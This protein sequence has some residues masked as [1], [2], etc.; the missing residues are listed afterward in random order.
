M[1]GK[2][3]GAGAGAGSGASALGGRFRGLFGNES[4]QDS[5][6][7]TSNF[8]STYNSNLTTNDVGAC[9]TPM[10]KK[11]LTALESFAMKNGIERNDP[12]GKYLFGA[13][14]RDAINGKSGNANGGGIIDAAEG[15]FK[16]V[17][18]MM[19]PTPAKKKR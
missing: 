11:R 14:Q 2:F 4:E 8:T 6:W 1:A 18:E 3:A 15:F 10:T 9:Q 13:T 5:E 7:K 17:N 16:K 19:T 12:E